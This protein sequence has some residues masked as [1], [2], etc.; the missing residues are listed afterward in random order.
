VR[1]ALDILNTAHPGRQPIAIGIALHAGTV[2]VGTIEAPARCE[3]TLVGD[4]VNVTE[5]LEKCN[6][7]LQSVRSLV[8]MAVTLYSECLSTATPLGPA[9]PVMK[10][11]STSVPS[12]FARP[13]VPLAKLVQ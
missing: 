12:R 2:L 10:L 13:I 6:K 3:Y 1:R 8:L 4:A 11:W 5:R 9:A 7:E